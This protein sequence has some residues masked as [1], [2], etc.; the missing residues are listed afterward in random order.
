M[1]WAFSGVEQP[2]VFVVLKLGLGVVFL[3]SGL[4]QV[5]TANTLEVSQQNEVARPSDQ[6]ATSNNEQFLLITS[7]SLTPTPAADVVKNWNILPGPLNTVDS[8]HYV[9]ISVEASR[10]FKL[11]I[12]IFT[13]LGL[14]VNKIEFAVPQNEFDKLAKGIKNN[15]R[16]MRVLWDNRAQD[17]TLAATGAYI[18]KTDVT[19]LKIPGISKDE[20]VHSDYRIVGLVRS[21]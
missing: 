5:V 3:F 7:P 2:G 8:S 16:V 13:N 17:G 11:S 21:P 1:L 6:V 10:A 12:N 14:F 18:L 19:L 20:E 9:G 4:S 15:T